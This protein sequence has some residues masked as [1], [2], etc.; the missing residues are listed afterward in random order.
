LHEGEWELSG[1]ICLILEAGFAVV[2]TRALAS[3]GERR[4]LAA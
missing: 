1:L 4:P 3:S 2:A